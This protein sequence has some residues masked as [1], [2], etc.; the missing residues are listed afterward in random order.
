MMH[1]IL[2]DA[3]ADVLRR[4]VRS[5]GESPVLFRNVVADE[6]SFRAY[7]RYLLVE[8][9]APM[10]ASHL[11]GA[12]VR[13]RG[14]YAPVGL[15]EG[16][17]LASTRGIYAVFCYA[18]D[19]LDDV[20]N[21]WYDERHMP[22]AMALGI[23]AR[24]VRYRLATQPS[25]PFVAPY[26]SIYETESDPRSAYVRWLQFRTKWAQDPDWARLLGFILSGGYERI[27]PTAA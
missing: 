4:V 25:D 27:D 18:R 17:L 5:A 14:G 10:P 21:R 3:P 26:L 15:A 16:G 1:T 9:S 22:E 23:Y 12:L 7:P 2:F 8:T 11:E 20:F 6:E 19:G 24:G 13:M